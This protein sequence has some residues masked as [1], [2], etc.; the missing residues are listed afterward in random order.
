MPMVTRRGVALLVGPALIVVN[1]R[2]RRGQRLSAVVFESSLSPSPIRYRFRV[3]YDGTDFAGWQIQPRARTVQGVIE[4]ALTKRFSGQPVTILGASRTDA[5]V[6]ARGQMAHA[7]L[8]MAVNTTM[9]EFQL[10]RMLPHDVRLF[11][12]EPAPA[13]TEWQA[14]Q[15]LQ[16][17]DSS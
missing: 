13:P 6:H 12:L 14:E 4:R 5:G 11:D 3:A 1:A 2:A 9:L 10:N 15:S 7:D 17:Y 16:W 8:P